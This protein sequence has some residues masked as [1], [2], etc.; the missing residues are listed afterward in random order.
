MRSSK[1]FTVFHEAKLFDFLCP[2]EHTPVFRPTDRH[3]VGERRWK[4]LCPER[5]E[6]RRRVVAVAAVEKKPGL[7]RAAA[8]VAILIATV[9]VSDDLLRREG[10]DNREDGEAREDDHGPVLVGQRAFRTAPR[11]GCDPS[12]RGVGGH[13]ERLGLE[14]AEGDARTVGARQVLRAVAAL[15]HGAHAHQVL[16]LV[17]QLGDVE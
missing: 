3:L 13:D 9:R 11:P 10:D 4:R 17:L 15:P 1:Q 7:R 16:A 2:T 14:R 5:V 8:V 6:G 12:R